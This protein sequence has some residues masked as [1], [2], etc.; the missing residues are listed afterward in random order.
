MVE[1]PE[2]SKWCPKG[3]VESSEEEC[4]H[5]SK[6]PCNQPIS[7]PRDLPDKGSRPFFLLLE[8][9]RREREGE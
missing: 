6:R 1:K 4:A 8:T 5:Q 7:I 2:A 3:S 9:K